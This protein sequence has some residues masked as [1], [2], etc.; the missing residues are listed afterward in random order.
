MNQDRPSAKIS[1]EHPPIYA[2]AIPTKKIPKLTVHQKVVYFERGAPVRENGS[3]INNCL[4]FLVNFW[5][6]VSY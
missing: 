1:H 3:Y 2:E 4:K 6:I 5:G